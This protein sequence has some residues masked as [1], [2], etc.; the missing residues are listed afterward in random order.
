MAEA[1]GEGEVLGI[2]EIGSSVGTGTGIAVALGVTCG[3]GEAEADG[4][5]LTSG[6][7]VAITSLSGAGVNSSAIVGASR[8][9]TKVKERPSRS[10]MA[11]ESARVAR[12][13]KLKLIL[14]SI[15]SINLS[16]N[17]SKY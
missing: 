14:L 11:R 2:G 5:A 7:A 3:S 17:M 16:T 1:D 15:R 10:R 4:G 12:C 13:E 9:T 6:V 8:K